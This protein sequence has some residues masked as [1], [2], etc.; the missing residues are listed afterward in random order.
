[1][2]LIKNGSIVNEGKIEVKD[3]LIENSKIV[4]VA[5]NINDDEFKNIEIIDANGKYILPGLIDTH[6]HFREPGLTKKED[7]LHGSMGA[8]AS[9]ITSIMEMPNTIPATISFDEVDNKCAIASEKSVTNYSFFIGVTNDNLDN[10]LVGD[11]SKTCGIKLFMGSSTGNMALKDEDKIEKLFKNAKAPIVIHAEDDKII[12]KN[13]KIYIEKYGDKI[14]MSAHSYIRSREACYK[15]TKKAIS[16]AKKYNTKIHIAHLSTKEELELFSD[17]KIEKKNITAEVCVHHL[18]FKNN[19]FDKLGSKIKC[20]P[21]IKFIEDRDALRKALLDNRLDTIATDH[22]PHTLE[23]KNNSDYF[24]TPSGIPIIENSLNI[25]LSL[26]HQKLIS[27]ELIVE[28][29]AHNPAKLFNIKNR[30]FIRE[31]SFADL[32]ILDLDLEWTKNTVISKC[33]WSPLSGKKFKGKVVETLVNGVTK[34]K[35]DQFF[36]D[37]KG[38]RLEFIY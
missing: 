28:K 13:S 9:G 17:D 15:S 8:V 14:P 16:L 29:M 2:R 3:I 7:I 6:V 33:G 34:F 18:F 20:N 27:L 32:T 10:I 11:Y 26:Y 24:S 30:G 36:V 38:E 31:G 21:S 22:A 12:E 19:D 4:K 25:M 37:V 35:D 23:E 5:K 1:M